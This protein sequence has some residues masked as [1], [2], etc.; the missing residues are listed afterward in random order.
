MQLKLV[1]TLL[2]ASHMEPEKE[3]KVD[4]VLTLLCKSTTICAIYNNKE[5]T[6]LT[7]LSIT[8]IIYFGRYQGNLSLRLFDLNHCYPSRACKSLWL[9]FPLAFLI[10]KRP[11][12][13]WRPW[14]SFYISIKLTTGVAYIIEEASSIVIKPAALV[15]GIELMG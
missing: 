3:I 13:I 12:C 14:Q 7:G 9:W 5:Q 6:L 4:K 10:W 1:D 2:K 8:W 15:R 11:G